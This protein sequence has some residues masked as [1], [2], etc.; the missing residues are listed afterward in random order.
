MSSVG[1]TRRDFVKRAAY[2]APVILTLTATPMLAR[3]GSRYEN[4]YK[5]IKGGFGEQSSYW[6]RIFQYFFGLLN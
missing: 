3:T 5:E 1:E 4:H 2:V 6:D